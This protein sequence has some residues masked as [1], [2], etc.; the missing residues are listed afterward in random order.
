MNTKN[1]IYYNEEGK[2][3]IIFPS[4]KKFYLLTNKVS[5][6][7]KESTETKTSKK[8][9]PAK[10]KE[11]LALL[12]EA[13]GGE[14]TAEE[15]PA[16]RKE[17]STV[18]LE[19]EETQ[20][21][22]IPKGMSK[23]AASK[24]LKNQWD[25]EE[26]EIDM[27]LELKEW[28]PRDGIHAIMIALEKTFGWINA[29]STFF[30]TPMELQIT[31]DIKDGKVIKKDAFLG[32][33]KCASW[34]NAMADVGISRDRTGR[35]LFAFFVINVKKK[36]KTRVKK[37][38]DLI[39]ETLKTQSIYKGKSVMVKQSGFEFVENKGEKNIIL[40]MDEE[41]IVNNLVIRP[42]GKPGKRTFLFTGI[43]GTGKTETALRV[44]REAN[45]KGMTFF[46]LKDPTLFSE[47]LE[48]AKQYAPSLL[49]LEDIDEIGSGE[50]RDNRMNDL[51]NTLDGVQT[52]GQ[53]LTVIFT[54]NH[55]NR[56][57]KAMRRPGRIDLVVKFKV[58]EKDT[59]KKIYEAILKA[60]P[61]FETLD[62]EAI[63]SYTPVVQGAVIA[64]ICKRSIDTAEEYG[65][66][67]NEIVMTSID[68]MKHQLEFMDAPPENVETQAE[69][70]SNAI[71]IAVARGNEL[72]ENGGYGG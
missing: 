35:E 36:H 34:D 5:P 49:F 58:C 69:K 15:N 19:S 24:E 51:L 60:I 42:L 37:F 45:S 27:A 68:S 25:E 9:T 64:E 28:Q 62:L 65:A 21:I 16:D 7:A 33:M 18:T 11:A 20:T 8:G 10:M 61:G 13:F 59:T 29:Q 1:I 46:Y 26:T 53:N 12:A 38:F 17:I 55:E 70:L 31:T 67:S 41:R 23:L 22:I 6:M 40:N 56:I 66:I 14:M 47:T 4:T 52:K 57:N 3:N 72:H 32:K 30:S 39:Q 44:G 71:E 48:S 63:T 54:T 2:I 43:Y 50:E